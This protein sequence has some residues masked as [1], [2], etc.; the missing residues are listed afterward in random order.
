MPKTATPRP[1][2]DAEKAKK[3][4]DALDILGYQDKAL[5]QGKALWNAGKGIIN[6]GL[7]SMIAGAEYAGDRSVTKDVPKDINRLGKMVAQNA[8]G[9][10]DMGNSLWQMVKGDGKQAAPD[11]FRNRAGQA[12]QEQFN[13]SPADPRLERFG[14]FYADPLAVGIGAGRAARGL[15]DPT[16]YRQ[17]ADDMAQGAQSNV[18]RRYGI[19]EDSGEIISGYDETPIMLNHPSYR[20]AKGGSGHAGFRVARDLMPSSILNRVERVADSNSI[21]VPMY[22]PEQH[23]YNKIPIGMAAYI[24]ERTGIPLTPDI[25]Q[26]SRVGHTGAG[27]MD[28]MIARPLFGGKVNKGRSHILVDDVVTMGGTMGEA[29]NYIQSLG[30]DIGGII[31]LI[32]KSKGDRIN[33]SESLVKDIRNRFGNAPEEEFGIVP[34]ALTRPEAEYLARFGSADNLRN[35]AASARAKKGS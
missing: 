8:G 2:S 25:I 24:S 34:E 11:Y 6:D 33:P 12:Y 21:L 4:K 23:G 26:S 31:S 19:P 13:P 5:A 28:R 27:A 7:A 18:V 17:I 9:Y 20:N 35:R 1:L 29:S 14:Q 15:A 22:S 3:R 32:N 30:G 10:A 16:L